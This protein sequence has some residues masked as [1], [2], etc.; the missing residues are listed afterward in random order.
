ML[1]ISTKKLMSKKYWTVTTAIEID[2]L[3]KE[4]ITK[5][6]DTDSSIADKAKM[7]LF[8]LITKKIANHLI[9]DSL[10]LYYPGYERPNLN[11]PFDSY[12]DIELIVPTENV[13]RSNF[14]SLYTKDFLD[15][16]LK[17]GTTFN[18]EMISKMTLW[19]KHQHP[20]DDKT[21]KPKIDYI[22]CTIT[23]PQPDA[24][25]IKLSKNF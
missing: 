22:T 17:K 18:T 10:R 3:I 19:L 13:Q 11:K 5:L 8:E 24:S 6:H 14:C 21:A 15:M 2:N 25:Q 16:F 23:P 7:D 1:A 12:I 4:I 9:K 20:A